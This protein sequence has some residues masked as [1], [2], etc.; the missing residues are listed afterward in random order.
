MSMS[1]SACD[2]GGCQAMVAVLL[3]RPVPWRQ[4]DAYTSSLI[5][6]LAHLCVSQ[7]Q[8]LVTCDSIAL[9]TFATC[10]S[11]SLG[12]DLGSDMTT[13]S[14]ETHGMHWYAIFHCV[15]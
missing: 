10:R 15:F 14:S 2:G 7:P 13:V 1:M 11:G 12:T 4:M 3:R 9:P 6:A 8:P 5:R